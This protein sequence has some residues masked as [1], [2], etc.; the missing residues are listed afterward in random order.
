MQASFIQ[1]ETPEGPTLLNLQNVAAVAVDENGTFGVRRRVTVHLAGGTQL[2][3]DKEYADRLI[4]RLQAEGL[5]TVA[6]AEG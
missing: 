1:V 2:T 5:L 6:P 3:F 4:S